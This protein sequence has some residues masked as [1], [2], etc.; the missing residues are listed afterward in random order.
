[1]TT[2]PADAQ[3]VLIA[4]IQK[5][6]CAGGLVEYEKDIVVAALRA[7]ADRFCKEY[8]NEECGDSADDWLYHIAA[9][10]EAYQ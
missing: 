6:E 7:A 1:M 5:M 4:V 9:E 10:L 3:A 2:L 8:A